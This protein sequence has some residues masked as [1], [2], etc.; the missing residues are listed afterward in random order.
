MGLRA[1]ALDEENVGAV[2][3]MYDWNALQAAGQHPQA[4]CP[5]LENCCVD[6]LNA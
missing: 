6:I 3:V 2:P 4:S 5:A 1:K